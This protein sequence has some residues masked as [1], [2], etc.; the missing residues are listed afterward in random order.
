[1][2]RGCRLKEVLFQE[3]RKNVE[4]DF[5]GFSV[6]VSQFVAERL[7]MQEP[8]QKIGLFCCRLFHESEY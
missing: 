1:M 4:G 6:V 3:Q 7:A 8:E 2:G 5:N